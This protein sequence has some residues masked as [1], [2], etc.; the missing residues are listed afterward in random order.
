MVMQPLPR[1]R[2][3]SSAADYAAIAREVVLR[4]WLHGDDCERLERAVVERHGVPDALCIAK[5][6]VGIFVTIRALIEPGQKVV[7][8]PYTISDVVNMVLC[9]GGV[10]VFADLEPDTCNVA[11]DEIA[12]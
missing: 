10:P 8:S 3:Y 2:I 9:A 11:A 6:R 7:L 5:A 12:W 1:Y 4:R